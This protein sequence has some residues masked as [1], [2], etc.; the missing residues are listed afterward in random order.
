MVNLYVDLSLLVFRVEEMVC[1]PR[2]MV[3]KLLRNLGCK[4][5]TKLGINLSKGEQKEVFKWFLASILFGAPLPETIVFKTYRE[6]ENENLLS[7]EKIVEAGWSKLVEVLDQGSYVRLDFKTATKLLNVM[8]NLINNY[9]GNLN[10]LHEQALNS[11]D[12]EKRIKDMGKGIGKITVSIF[13]R[14]LRGI[15]LKANPKP[16][17]I[18]VLAAENLGIITTKEPGK[19]LKELKEFWEVNRIPEKDFISFETALMKLG[20]DFCKKG[21]CTDCLVKKWCK[22]EREKF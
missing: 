3:E 7:P 14:E 20:K 18:T 16:T 1:S 17:P 4:Y 22:R 21:K 10:I 2:E 11:E 13:L 9:G 15:W 6:F 5:S 8:N 12:L 19:A